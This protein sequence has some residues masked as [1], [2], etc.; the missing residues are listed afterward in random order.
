MFLTYPPLSRSTLSV[1]ESGLKLNESGLDLKDSPTTYG[2]TGVKY[3]S[4]VASC[5]DELS[6]VAKYAYVPS[7]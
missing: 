4:N 1:V 3:L 6:I 7:G 2:N 5:C